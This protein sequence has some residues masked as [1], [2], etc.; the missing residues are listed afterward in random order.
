[1]KKSGSRKL[2][3]IF[4]VI[5]ALALSVI[6][7][8][9]AA[10]DDGIDSW[11]TDYSETVPEKQYSLG[12]V[13]EASHLNVTVYDEN[14]RPDYLGWS[15][16]SEEMQTFMD[17]I[18]GASPAAGTTDETFADLMI[19]YFENGDS[20]AIT[21]SR[22]RGLLMLNDQLYQP[23]EDITTLIIRGEERFD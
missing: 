10:D 3:I 1:M 12:D 15:G 14:G 23:A 21:Y 4:L 7:V 8:V 16:G 18:A 19:F 20:M 2:F 22:E 9:N 5:V 17:A 11:Q 13:R 6:L